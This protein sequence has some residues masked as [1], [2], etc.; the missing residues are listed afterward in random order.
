MTMKPVSHEVSIQKDSS[1]AGHEKHVRKWV[2]ARLRRWAGSGVG[3]GLASALLALPALAQATE[4][5]LSTFQ[6]A[7]VLPG[8]Q[9]VKLLPN[10]DVQLKLLDGRT[11]LVSAENVHVLDNG[12]IM[13]AEDVAVEVAQLAVA[14]EAAGAAAAGGGGMGAAGA[15]LGG[16]GLAGAAAAGGGG[17]EDAATPAESSRPPSLNLSQLQG[18][19]LNSTTANSTAPDGTVSVEVTIGSVT[20]TVSAGPDGSWSVSLSQIEAAGLPQGFTSVTI[21]HLDGAGGEIAVETATYNI[22]TIAPA[23]A[24]TGFSHGAVMNA[25][26]SASDLEISGTTDAENG[27]MVTVGLNGQIYTATVSGGT[28]SVT[29][30]AADLASLPDGATVTV[31]ADVVDRAGNPAGQATNSFDTDFSAPAITIDA[32]AGG[33]IDLVDVGS[34]LTITGTTTGEDGQPVVLTFNGQTYSGIASGGVWSVTVPAADLGVLVSGSPIS[35]SAA[36]S[37]SAGNPAT[38]AAV[39][40]PVDL[41]GPSISISPLSVGAVLNAAEVGADLTISGTTGNV[42]DGQT[43]TVTLDG[44]TYTGPVSGGTWSVTV[45]S[46][47][48]IALTDGAT[49]TITADVTDAD[50]LVAPQ[51]SAGVS[52]DATAPTISIDT[53]S[54]GGVMNAVEQGTNL[55]ISGTTT[56]E[57]GQ[58]V[59]IGMNGQTYS[60]TVSGGNWSVSVPSADLAGLS[61]GATVTVTADV[62]D[63]AG[64]P[65]AQAT[66][67][68]DTDFTAPTLSISTVSAGGAM[69]LAEQSGGMTV[70]GIS[71]APDGTVVSIQVQRADGTVDISGTATVTSG[72][73][74]YTASPLDLSG[75]QDAESYT[76]SASVSDAAGNTQTTSTGFNTDF[77]APTIS[78]NPLGTGSVLDVTEKDSDLTVSGTTTAEDGQ[79]ITVGLNG[80]TYIATGS[81]G[82]WSTTITTADLNALSDGTTYSIT[83]SVSDI[84]GNPATQAAAS[85]TTDYRPILTLN[86]VGT[87]DAVSL[88]DA[89]SS[90]LTVSGSSIGLG[91]GQTVE[92]MLNSV[93][94]GTATVAANGTWSLNVPATAFSGTTAGDL[95]DFSV[96]ATVTGGPNPLP[97]TDQATAHVPAAYFI[98]E[99]GRSGSTIA[100]EIHADA[101]RDIFSGMAFTANLGFDPAVV[102]YDTGSEVENT[103]FDLFL[104]NPNG[105]AE[106]SFGGAATSF[107]DLTQ[108]IVTFTMTVLDPT[109]PIELTINTPDGGPTHWVLGTDGTDTLAATGIDDVIRGGDGDDVID[110]SGVGRDLIVFE[111]DPMANGTDIVTGF[112]LGPAADMA[113]AIMFSGLDVSSLRGDGTGVETLA[114]GDMIATNT[115]FVGLTTTLNDLTTDTLETAAETLTG[116]QAGDEIYLLASDG[117]DSVLVKVD[118]SAPTSATVSTVAQFDGLGDLSGL[119]SDNILHTDPTGAS[120]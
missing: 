73:W 44:Q 13:I 88:S 21:R 106:I 57:D 68:F 8:V 105:A 48:L 102:T 100:F 104:A 76:V 103:D 27:Q 18:N 43:V 89:Q 19:S 56:A 80:Q 25:A 69:N 93:S 91:A 38:P 36:I 62:S 29:V 45:P 42:T 49:F 112:T 83:A 7:D 95:L 26:E 32:V 41:S 35:I 85:V 1:D 71:D 30:P 4:E 23:I 58:T 75:L 53:F 90:G 34:D 47:E 72:A 101:D 87:N 74:T 65:A 17:G 64:N 37:D 51:A 11:V 109:K 117:T 108:P 113:D 97:A 2:K 28:W 115:G 84:A 77:S 99:A 81:G 67:S 116:A 16:L 33:Q 63:L 61:D 50:G 55:S 6:F 24:V 66:G 14:A 39:S 119:S 5:E 82:V 110:L 92:V 40:V 59:T 22:D 120:S 79:T 20:K 46:A 60:A 3:G 54:D 98:S 78:L 94:V 12:S 111:A 15:V 31:T 9:S 52:K 114:I 86:E 96:S 107:S 10:G 118:Y 70:S